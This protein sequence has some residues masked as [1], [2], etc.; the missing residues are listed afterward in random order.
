MTLPSAQ[1][2]SLRSQDIR[3]AG[4]PTGLDG[5]IIRIDPMTGLAAA[6]NPVHRPG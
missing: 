6:G 3:T 5:T 1:G 2:G 4:D